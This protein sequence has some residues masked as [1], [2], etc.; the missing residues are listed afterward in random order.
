MQVITDHTTYETG[1]L[2]LAAGAWSKDLGGRQVEVLQPK[3]V[4]VHWLTPPD[5]RVFALKNFPVN[6]WQVPVDDDPA[7]PE[8]YKEFYSLPTLAPDGYV[9]IAFHNGLPDGDPATRPR[10]VHENETAMIKEII[11]THLPSLVDSPCRVDVCFYMMT[12]DHHF[13]L[14]RLPGVQHVYGAALAGHGFKFAPVLGELLADLLTDMPS[15]FDCAL[16][17]PDRFASYQD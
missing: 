16:F 3:W 14:G 4:A 5:N 7:Y 13:F 10:E 12:P 15:E 2:L 17:S 1:R 11:A 9:K 6:F 8:G